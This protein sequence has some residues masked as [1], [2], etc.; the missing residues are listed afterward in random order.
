MSQKILKVENLKKYF[1]IKKGIILSKTIGYVHAVDNVSL[2]VNRM[3]TVGIVGESGS[4]KTTLALCILRLL[5]P[6]GGKIF[7]ENRDITDLKGRELRKLRTEMQIIF[8]DPFSSLNPRMTV[9][10]IIGEPLLIHKK[11][12]K[13]EVRSIVEDLMIKVGLP[14]RHMNRYPHEFSGG[15]RQRIAIARAIAI[16]PKLLIAD[17]P[18]SQLDV[19]IQA[20][21]LKLLKDLKEEFGLTILFITHNL[22]IVYNFCDKIYV[23][24]LGKIMESGKTGEIFISPANPY[25]AA[26]LSAIPIPD[27]KIKRRRIILKGETPSP[28]NPP[29][30]CRFHPRCFRAKEICKR[31]EPPRI[32]LGGDHVVYCHFPL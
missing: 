27:P 30:G 3:E 31:E 29:S 23:M 4:G 7:F 6:T 9:G 12:S 22:G 17:E 5:E 25:T 20:Q 15:Q 18:T 2:K 32:N 10:R 24:Y 28:I 19:S 11:M 14:P 13:D 8:Q 21:I 1:P 16:K 26:L